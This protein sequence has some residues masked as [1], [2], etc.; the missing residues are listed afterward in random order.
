M[1]PRHKPHTSRAVDVRKRRA[2]KARVGTVRRRVLQQRSTLP[3]RV[4]T[5]MSSAASWSFLRFFRYVHGS[6]SALWIATRGRPSDD[7]VTGTHTHTHTQHRH[8]EGIRQKTR[9]LLR[10]SSYRVQHLT[11]PGDSRKLQRVGSRPAK[12]S[13]TVG[14][15]PA[16]CSETVQKDTQEQNCSPWT[17]S[18]IGCIKKKALATTQSVAFRKKIRRRRRELVLVGLS[19]ACIHYS[20]QGMPNGV[21]CGARMIT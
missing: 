10:G 6:S 2:L 15:R 12:C 14:S 17:K 3:V 8:G 21:G 16:K 4:D 19:G 13:E 18:L 5:V 1:C 11:A 9:M 20:R 7:N